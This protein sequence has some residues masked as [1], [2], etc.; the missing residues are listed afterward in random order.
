MLGWFIDDSARHLNPI[1]AGPQ[2]LYCLLRAAAARE[3]VRFRPAR[4]SIRL[5]FS[6]KLIAIRR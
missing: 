6:G 5:Q 1:I 2:R 3:S 4:P